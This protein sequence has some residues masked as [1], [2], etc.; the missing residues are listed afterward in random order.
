VGDLVAELRALHRPVLTGP[1]VPNP[2]RPPAD[3]GGRAVCASCGPTAW[4]QCDT[5]RLLDQ[6]NAD[7]ST[8]PVG[9]VGPEG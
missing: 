5:I 3:P 1:F 9:L 8:Q 4:W 2:Y 6:E 7:G